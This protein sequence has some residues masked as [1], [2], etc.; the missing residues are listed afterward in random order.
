ML[1]VHL[2]LALFLFLAVG[3]LG[4]RAF[5]FLGRATPTAKDDALFR[6]LAYTWWGVSLVLA[7]S[8]LVYTLGLPH[9]PFRSFGERLLL[10]AGAKG[11]A[12][13]LILLLTW[14]AFLSVPR[15]LAQIPEPEGEFSRRQVRSRTLRAVSETAL[16]ALVVTLGGLF[17]LSNL[18]LNISA[19][20][21]GAG[22]AGL[23]LSLAAQNLIRDVISG[24]FILLEDQ[25]GVGDVVK[26]GQLGGVVERFNLRVTVLRDLE[27]RVHFIPNSQ[28]QPVTVLT[29]EWARAVVDVS[30]AYKE[31]LERVLAL[32]KE[33]ADRLHQ[34]WADRLTGAP[35]VLGVEA[36]GESGAVLRVVF[37]TKAKEH[38]DVA[39]EF[40]LRIKRRF[41]QE[42]I[43]PAFPHRTVYFGG[44]LAVKRVD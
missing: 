8:Y 5:L 37:P 7:L 21:T 17:F 35:E 44:V 16:K 30:V 19:L 22:V 33:E 41:D 42:G 11:V 29:Q 39:R 3:R 15:L 38:W 28:A 34:D 32:L 31:D 24:F 10:W 18:G 20:L 9:E 4:Y 2:A 43:E 27:G 25:Y 26:I 1:A 13:G 40:R 14:V 12:G 23:A 36:L 6:L